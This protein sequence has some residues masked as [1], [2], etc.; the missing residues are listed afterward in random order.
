MKALLP[1]L[2]ALSLAAC[3]TSRMSDGDR[4]AMYRAH[5]GEPVSRIRYFNPIGWGRVDGDHLVLDMR[6]SQSWL[7]RVSGACLDWN[8]SFALGISSS[9]GW[10]STKFDRIYTN[11]APMSCVIQE[12]RPLDRKA[13]RA[14]E[15][16]RR[17]QSASGT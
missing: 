7:I 8:S 15:N 4:L 9:A 17:A 14:D 16:A 11:D 2:A 12:I 1:L 5:A 3:A 13:L 10:V 6:P